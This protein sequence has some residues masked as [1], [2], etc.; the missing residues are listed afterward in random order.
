M[1]ANGTAGRDQLEMH[2]RHEPVA[3]VILNLTAIRKLL[4]SLPYDREQLTGCRDRPH[5]PDVKSL[6][7]FLVW[8]NS[9]S[10]RMNIIGLS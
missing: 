8:M 9:R 1:L 4:Y 2:L 7:P 5:Q 3:E 10:T 6:E